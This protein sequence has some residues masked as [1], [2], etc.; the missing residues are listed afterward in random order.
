MKH[1]FGPF[2]RRLQRAQSLVEFTLILPI[3]MMMT[4]SIA[5]FGMAYG[6]N[7]SMIEATREGARVGAVLVAGGNGYG[8]SGIS[9][10]TCVDPQIIL[11]VERVIGSP[12]SGIT[13]AN[14]DYIHIFQS[15]DSGNES[16]A[17]VWT[18]GNSTACGLSLHF[19]QGAHPWDA[20]TRSNTLPVQAIGV[21]IQYQYKLF[22]PLSAITGLFGLNTMTMVDSTVM[23][24]EP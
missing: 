20:S 11:A 24:L 13:L 22:T 21:R 4:L 15:D 1:S 23:D 16:L 6:T 9:G 17:N 5:E 10:S 2:Q 12:G 18:Q 7:M 19:T 14:V 3:I 8:M